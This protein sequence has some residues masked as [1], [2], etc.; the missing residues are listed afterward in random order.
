MRA[1]L[2]SLC[3]VSPN[4]ADS[5]RAEQKSPPSIHRPP[6]PTGR[7]A[8]PHLVNPLLQV[9]A[10]RAGAPWA[11]PPAAAPPPPHTRPSARV[12]GAVPGPRTLPSSPLTRTRAPLLPPPVPGQTNTDAA[13]PA[14]S[15]D[16][17]Q[18]TPSSPPPPVPVVASWVSKTPFIIICHPSIYSQSLPICLLI[19]TSRL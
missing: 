1:L 16:R 19:L 9:G 14:S 17:R 5:A 11:L 2:F 7:R 13:T 8:A 6:P 10:P 4:R 12:E 3:S 18:Q 15:P